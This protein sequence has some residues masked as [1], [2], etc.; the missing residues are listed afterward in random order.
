MAITRRSF[1][2]ASTGF[3]LAGA[4]PAWSAQRSGSVPRTPTRIRLIRNATC[5]ISYGGKTLLLDPWLSDAGAM[6]P[7]NN[8]PNPR[9][10]PLVP[11]PVP[12]GQVLKGI[13][14]ALL[15]HTH[16][17]HWDPVARDLLPKNL[18]LFVQAPD[19]DR[20]AQAGFT[21]ARTVES[22]VRWEGLTLTPT[23]AQHGRGEMAQRMGPV[24][25]YVLSHAGSPTVYIAADTVWVPEVG[26]AIRTH[27]PEIIVVNAGEAQFLQ[28]GPII[29]GVDD[30]VTVCRT[31]PD[32]TVIAVHMEAVN[33]CVL[34]R[35]GLRSGL[36]GAQVTSKVLIPRDGDEIQFD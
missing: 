6:P 17:D 28:G 27:K 1:L 30:V 34:S 12:A 20:I 11:L 21:D 33:H 7:I 23:V 22:L 25:G 2:K 8:T 31:A 15:T 13:D 24:S 14:A 10:N 16:F 3:A 32:A 35:E 36:N 19:R 29:M 9:P 5:I 18:A 26:D 4:A